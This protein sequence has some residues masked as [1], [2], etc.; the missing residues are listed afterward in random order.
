[1][2]FKVL[3]VAVV[4]VLVYIL[5]FKKNRETDVVDLNK[6]SKKNK[7]ESDEMYECPSCGVFVSKNESVLS[8]GKYYC[9]KECLNNK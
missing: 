3:A 9:S 6:R 5:F 7:T 2:I 8:N 1:M 4:L